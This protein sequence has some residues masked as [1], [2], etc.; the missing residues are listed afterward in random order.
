MTDIDEFKNFSVE[1]F[2]QYITSKNISKPDVLKDLNSM[3]FDNSLKQEILQKIDFA[4]QRIQSQLDSQSKVLLVFFP[5]GIVNI[6]LN[7]KGFFDVEEQ[8][9]LGFVKKVKQYYD[10]SIIGILLYIIII[11]VSILITK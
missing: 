1:N 6:L 10:Y 7:K 5:F 4:Y 11:L 9:R 3:D 2:I 8:K